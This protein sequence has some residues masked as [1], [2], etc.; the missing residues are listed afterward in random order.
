MRDDFT[1]AHFLGLRPSGTPAGLTTGR[2]AAVEETEAGRPL[3]R[4]LARW[5]GAG[6][7]VLARTS[8]HALI[9]VLSTRV[10]DAVILLDEAVYPIGRWAVGAV[11]AVGG[12]GPEVVRFRHHDAD[13]AR[14]RAPRR[15]RAV[16]VTDGLCG[17]CLRPAPLGELADVARRHDG[18]LVVDDTLA[19]GVLGRRTPMAPVLGSGGGGT[20]A[21]LGVEPGLVTVASLAKGLS[22]PLA[23]VTG[24]GPRV[25]RVRADGPTRV[26]A[27]PPT[28]ADVA[29]LRHALDDP[30]LDDRRARLAGHVV[31][32]RRVLAD[33]RMRPLGVGFPLVATEGG[34][35]DPLE[36]HRALAA[37]GIR[38][39]ATTGRCTGRPTLSLCLRADHGEAEMQRLEQALAGAV[40]GRAA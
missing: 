38:S 39:L 4:R 19:A 7:G 23:V 18:E 22:A 13:D 33:L 27:G 11:G 25:A 35:R 26:H 30:S 29:A 37:S 16:V 20:A 32:V 3:T 10:P 9:D 12:S 36:V 31:R 1:S 8:L 14:R 21:W 24:P 6:D 15:R 34:R 40:T 17:S 5:H 28:T 2:P